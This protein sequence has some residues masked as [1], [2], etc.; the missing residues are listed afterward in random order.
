VTFLH[1]V[2]WPYGRRDLY[3]V[4]ERIPAD[5]RQPFARS[6]IVRG[7]SELSPRGINAVFANA[8]HEGGP[9][10]GVLTA[11]E[12][13]IDETQRELELFILPGDEGLGI[14]V[15]RKRL[16]RRRFAR[17]LRE[18]YDQQAAAELSPRHASTVLA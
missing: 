8:K 11:V 10:N 18:L 16:R 12:D 3:Y 7:R 1:D 4:P 5:Q 2:E 9:R 15:D 17:V 14:V 6:G 13:F